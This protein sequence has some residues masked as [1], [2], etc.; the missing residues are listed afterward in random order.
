MAKDGNCFYASLSNTLFG[1][2]KYWKKLKKMLLLYIFCS[3]DTTFGN[4]STRTQNEY[5]AKYW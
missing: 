5:V 4:Y 1:S 3:W 2:R